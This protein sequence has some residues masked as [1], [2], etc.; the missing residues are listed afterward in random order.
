MTSNAV[1]TL[2]HPFESGALPPHPS[3]ERVLFVGAEPGFRRP[4]GFAADIACVQGFRPA[5]LALARAGETV[6]PAANG[7]DYDAVLLLV[8][9]HRGRNELY[10][11][12]ALGRSRPGATVVVAGGKD[13]GIASLRKRF[14]VLAPVD[15][16]AP[17]HH[18]IAF[19]FRRPPDAAAVEAIL[20]AENPEAV[21]EE[22][23]RAAPGMFSHDRADPGSTMLVAHLPDG[24]SGDVADFG[25]GWGY[26]A[27]T[28]A[29]RFTAVRSIDLYEADY[30]SLE[31]ARANMAAL[32]PE[33]KAGFHWHDLL[34]EQVPRR[35]DWI[36]MNPPFH[37]A[38]AG[39]PGI[40]QGMIAAAAKALKPG[41]RLAM[42]ANA[43][44]PY[45]QALGAAFKDVREIAREAG[46]KV[47]VARR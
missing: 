36:V 39:D 6:D 29:T 23:F 4:E 32:A 47:I 26:I 25:A 15:G 40:G 14:E 22:R 1:K 11:A 7:Q 41:G 43:H 45:E 10:I 27:A 30:A 3:G 12:E 35:Y 31:A 38:R 20:R 37:A 9:R 5:Y 21:V 33:T 24:I 44:L 13:D 18:G 28:V 2:F 42:V 16:H 8:G 34:S 46:F 17:K 19:W